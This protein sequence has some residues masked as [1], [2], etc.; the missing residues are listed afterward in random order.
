MPRILYRM[1]SLEQL[2]TTKKVARITKNR[3][4]ITGIDTYKLNKKCKNE[5]RAANQL[6]FLLYNTRI[7]MILWNKK[8]KHTSCSVR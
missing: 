2:R 7:D 3:K 6:S 4:K 1:F 8:A 5:E